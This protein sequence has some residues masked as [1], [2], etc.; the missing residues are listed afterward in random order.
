[1]A[2]HHGGDP[3]LG[4][5]LEF[6]PLTLQDSPALTLLLHATVEQTYPQGHTSEGTV[7]SAV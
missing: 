7:Q 5:F 1:M 2:Y 3:A 6:L 4:D